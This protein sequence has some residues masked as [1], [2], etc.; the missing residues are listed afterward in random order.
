MITQQQAEQFAREWIDAFN[1]RDLDAMLSHYA[2]DVEFTSPIVVE[3]L[4]DPSGTI[5]GKEALRS[6]FEKGLAAY[7]NL[8]FEVLHVLAGVDSV[9]IVHQSVHRGGPGAEVMTLDDRGQVAKVTVHY[10]IAPK[11][12]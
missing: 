6:Y 2:N 3:L 5:R 1:R 10:G 9:C 12:R 8:G 7:P 11:K 4:G